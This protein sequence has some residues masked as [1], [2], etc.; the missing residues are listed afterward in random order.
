MDRFHPGRNHFLRPA[1]QT[2]PMTR[3]LAIL[4]ASAMLA[5]ANPSALASGSG[6]G[7]GGGAR[8]PRKFTTAESYVVVLPFAISI[9]ERNRVKGIFIVEFGIDVPDAEL[10]AKAEEIMP[11][12]RDAWLRTLSLY[13]QTMLRTDRQADI[14]S[15][16]ARLQTATN[17]GLGAEGARV[18]MM[19]AVVRKSI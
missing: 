8:A 5:L 16:S 13:G 10:R 18:L 19:Q 14:D 2:G 9:I 6:E 17:Q 1:C 12:L 3:F 4:L 7:E 15:L 11:R